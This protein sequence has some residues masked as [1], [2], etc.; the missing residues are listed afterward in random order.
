MVPGKPCERDLWNH[1]GVKTHRLRAV[2][3]DTIHCYCSMKKFFC[4]ELLA[5]CQQPFLL[6]AYISAVYSTTQPP[7]A[8]YGALPRISGSDPTP[9][10]LT[11]QWINQP[12]SLTTSDREILQHSTYQDDILRPN[13]VLWPESQIRTCR[14]A[15]T[16]TA[17]SWGRYVMLSPN[18]IPIVTPAAMTKISSLELGVPFTNF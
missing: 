16:S 8:P 12:M 1:K 11:H 17:L 15:L 5:S 6:P 18:L 9:I 10:L 13:S 2:G 3:K 14:L 7:L 4:M